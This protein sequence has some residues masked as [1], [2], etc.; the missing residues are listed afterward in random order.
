M[1]VH[2]SNYALASNAIHYLDLYAYLTGVPVSNLDGSML[3]EDRTGNRRSGYRE[4]V[5]TLRGCGSC[6]APVSLTSY[7]GSHL[8]GTVQFVS[9]LGHYIVDE[10]E[11]RLRYVASDTE[12]RWREESFVSYEVSGMTPVYQNILDRGACALTPYAEAAAMHRDLIEVYN[13]LF[14]GSHATADQACPIT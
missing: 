2:G 1:R 3:E 10:G 5:G 8:P 7:P 11:K 14:F 12:W 9:E 6:G 4:I 13:R